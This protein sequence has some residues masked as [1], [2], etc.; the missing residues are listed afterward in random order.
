METSHPVPRS[1][2][3]KPGAAAR[4]KDHD[5]KEVRVKLD[6]LTAPQRQLVRALIAAAAS[7][8]TQKEDSPAVEMPS[9]SVGGRRVSV[10]PS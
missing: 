8:P 7:I 1:G 10:N 3:G 2:R 5:S 9:E 6:N 4:W